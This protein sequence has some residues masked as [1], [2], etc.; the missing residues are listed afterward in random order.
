MKSGVYTKRNFSCVCFERIF[1]HLRKR[2]DFFPQLCAALAVLSIYFSVVA[3]WSKFRR[4]PHEKIY[5]HSRGNLIWALQL[6]SHQC[7][8][9]I[10]SAD[11]KN[12]L[13]N[14]Y[15]RKL[16]WKIVEVNFIRE[17]KI[18]N[19]ATS[20]KIHKIIFWCVRMN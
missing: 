5:S 12:I 17:K 3:I 10:G 19:Q 11:R 16:L 7:W 8:W 13:H 14:K 9:S 20:D 15:S 6:L 18:V 4:C 2:A 1:H